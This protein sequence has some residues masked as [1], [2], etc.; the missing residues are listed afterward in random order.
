[1]GV[2]SIWLHMTTTM[3]SYCQQGGEDD[4]NSA[5]PVASGVQMHSVVQSTCGKASIQAHL[6]TTPSETNASTQFTKASLVCIK[7]CRRDD[8][9]CPHACNRSTMAV[10]QGCLTGC[11]LF[12][13]CYDVL[14]GTACK[15]AA[16]STCEGWDARACLGCLCVTAWTSLSDSCSLAQLLYALGSGTPWR[17]T[18]FARGARGTDAAKNIDPQAGTLRSAPPCKAQSACKTSL[19]QPVHLQYGSSVVHAKL[20]SCQQATGSWHCR[21]GP[22]EAEPWQQLHPARVSWSWSCH[23]LQCQILL[24]HCC[25]PAQWFVHCLPVSCYSRLH[26]RLSCCKAW[27]HHASS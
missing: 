15:A 7:T 25:T 20:D 27:L 11:C 9:R 4:D 16:T 24:R 10:W 1:M 17:T 2:R 23:Q 8:C 18:F 5:A 13:L 3:L 26:V 14:P 21:S 19:R 12:E 22:V 6:K